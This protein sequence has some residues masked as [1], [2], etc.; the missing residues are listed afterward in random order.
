[1]LTDGLVFTMFA[2]NL[3]VT[4]L[5]SECGTSNQTFCTAGWACYANIFKIPVVY[6]L[7]VGSGSVTALEG[8]GKRWHG[9][10]HVWA[11]HEEGL[12]R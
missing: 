11:S 3:C 10:P 2:Y 12:S 1:M 6:A 5:G 8:V 9:S 7:V 4:G